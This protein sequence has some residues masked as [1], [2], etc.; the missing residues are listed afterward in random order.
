VRIR[1]STEAPG[2]AGAG[3]TGDKSI[4]GTGGVKEGVEKGGA[5][6]N[7]ADPTKPEPPGAAGTKPGASPSKGEIGGGV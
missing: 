2:S 5:G 3:G 4:E 1:D 7:G 6:D